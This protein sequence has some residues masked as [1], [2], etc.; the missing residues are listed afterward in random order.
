MS[1]VPATFP[2][3]RLAETIS[4]SATSFRL[5]DIDGWDGEEIDP[6]DLGT[7]LYATF[8]NSSGTLMEIMEVDTS[9]I[10]DAA[11]PIT[12]NK[13]GLAFNGSLTTQ[14][15][16][17]KLTWVRGDTIVEL[18]SHPPQIFQYYKEYAD[19]LT[20]AGAPDSSATVKGIVEVATTAE[21]NSGAS[22]GGTTAP[23]V[24]T[25]AAAAASIYGLQLPSAEQKIFLNAT[26]G[27][28]SAYVGNSA[29]TGFLM[30]DGA[31][32]A[33]ATY[34]ALVTVMAGRYG[35]GTPVT[36]TAATTDICTATSHGLSDG[37]LVFVANSG[38]ALPTGLSANTPYYLRDT[39]TNTFKLALTAGG[40]AVD[41]TGTGSGTNS[42]YTTSKVPY[43]NGATMVGKGQRVKTFSFLDAAVNTGT[44]VIT[45]ESNQYLYTGQAVV[46]SNSGGTLPGGL[47]ATTYYVIRLS[48]TTI[49]L[50]SSV[51]NANM[52]T[53]VD[54][55]TA[56]GGGT[57]TLT[58]TLTS[59]SVGDEGGVET[60]TGV[61]THNHTTTAQFE[62]GGSGSGGTGGG[63]D[64]TGV[65]STVG[66]SDPALT[67]NMPPFLTV[68]FV[69]KT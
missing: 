67:T 48:A 13:R 38:G 44:D 68:S 37:Q 42:F 26:T 29:P 51:F 34:P 32:I 65:I 57:H 27:M 21:V 33:N 3:K 46:L 7:V 17:N 36:F 39:T 35:Y 62:N 16:A 64:E 22:S 61:G 6:A 59:R 20:Y 47:S 9:T 54:I 18:G 55:T 66:E 24:V 53:P 15:A 4:A 49:K 43:L 41:I 69:V 5:S 52:A 40:A 8:R 19:G 31:T 2:A 50:A 63:V 10:T 60:D 25:P 30:C 11:S 12:I 45:V 23:L 28:I 14:V 1:F 58:L 56:A